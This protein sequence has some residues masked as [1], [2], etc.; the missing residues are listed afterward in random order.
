MRITALPRALMVALLPLMLGAGANGDVYNLSNDWSTTN[1]PNGVWSYYVNNSLAVAGTRT[2]D[3]FSNPPGAPALWGPG[4]NTYV[5]W[6]LS[7]G[8]EAIN[9][10]DLDTGDVYGHTP[11][12]G[13]I[14]IQWTSP[15]DGHVYLSG[16]VWRIRNIGRTNY[17]E[18]TFNGSVVGDDWTGSDPIPIDEDFV[19]HVG[20]VI[21]FRAT[22]GQT[23]D[24]LAMD[25]TVETVP[26][27][28]PGALLLGSLGLGVAGW[29]LKRKTI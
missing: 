20:D 14:E 11:D 28:L 1:N 10:W 21:G 27:P 8:S 6:S 22:A 3:P 25:V 23:P 7:N 2:G 19:V 18:L 9:G 26:V 12:R 13:S 4:G 24:Y 29:R 15:V 16:S 5:G 17:C